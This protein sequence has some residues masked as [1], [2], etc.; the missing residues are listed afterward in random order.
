M[1]NK[2][3]EVAHLQAE[4][5]LA[6]ERTKMSQKVGGAMAENARL[7]ASVELTR[8]RYELLKH[9]VTQ[10]N[11]QQ[12]NDLAAALAESKAGN[13][14]LKERIVVLGKHLETLRVRLANKPAD[15]QVK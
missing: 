10:E 2:E 3:I 6:N 4:L 12:A 7:K 9:V 11:S 1:L 5:R 8:D 13:A 15:G 14:R